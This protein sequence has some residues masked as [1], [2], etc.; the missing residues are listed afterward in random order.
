MLQGCH[1]QAEISLSKSGSSYG[2]VGTIVC[3][4]PQSPLGL[5]LYVSSHPSHGWSEVPRYHEVIME[6]FLIVDRQR[7]MLLFEQLLWLTHS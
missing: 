5:G 3:V 1:S 2:I 4:P 7:T 6:A